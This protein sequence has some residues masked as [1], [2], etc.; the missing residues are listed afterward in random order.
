MPPT[1]RT[2]H[3]L[4]RERAAGALDGFLVAS[5]WLIAAEDDCPEPDARLIDDLIKVGERAIKNRLDQIDP[6]RCKPISVSLVRELVNCAT[7]AM[8]SAWSTTGA[9]VRQRSLESLGSDG[10]RRDGPPS[11]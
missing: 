10:G 2:I 4:E 8:T 6:Q 7:L 11:S 1:C 5:A 3:A 9:I